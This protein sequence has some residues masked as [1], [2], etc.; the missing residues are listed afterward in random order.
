MT[1]DA[2]VLKQELDGEHFKNALPLYG[3]TFGDSGSIEG[4]RFD[5]AAVATANREKN[6]PDCKFILACGS[7]EFIRERVEKRCKSTTKYGF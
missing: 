1:M 4:S 2:S 6:Q 3:A 5:L 7:K